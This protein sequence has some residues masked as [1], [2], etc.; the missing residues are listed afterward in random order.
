MKLATR[1][2][3]LAI[4]FCSLTLSW[5]SLSLALT[6]WSPAETRPLTFSRKLASSRRPSASRRLAA[7]SPADT[8]PLTFSRNF[9]SSLGAFSPADTRP[10]SLSRKI[11]SSRGA[12]SMVGTLSWDTS[13]SALGREAGAG[14]K[15][16]RSA[17]TLSIVLCSPPRGSGCG[18]VSAKGSFSSSLD[19]DSF[20]AGID[21]EGISETSGGTLTLPLIQSRIRR[22]S[23]AGGC[24]GVDVGMGLRDGPCASLLIC[25]VRLSR[26]LPQHSC[27]QNHWPPRSCFPS[28]PHLT[29]GLSGWAG[30]ADA[31]GVN[32]FEQT[33]LCS[34]QCALWQPGEQ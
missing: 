16:S 29:Q 31:G 33:F 24:G 5:S 14:L 13:G 15:D 17:F 27:E 11:G 4:S 1:W 34:R 25:S 26:L 2:F 8:M 9:G 3:S 21:G 28:F 30:G 6:P 7:F 19:P 22:S 10:L 23:P 18:R 32:F 12:C 20:G